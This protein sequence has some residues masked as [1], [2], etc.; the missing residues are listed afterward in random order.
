MLL[1]Q[2]SER[3]TTYCRVH[4]SVQLSR[5]HEVKRHKIY[6][7]SPCMHDA[8]KQSCPWPLTAH[9]RYRDRFNRD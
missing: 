5:G 2:M 1:D 7:Q 8:Y 9:C 4:E 6:M 3:C